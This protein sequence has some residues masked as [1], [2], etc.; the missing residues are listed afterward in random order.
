MVPSRAGS[1]GRLDIG[2]AIHDGWL[3]FSRAPWAFVLFALLLTGLQ[4]L[5]QP[6]QEQV[7]KGARGEPLSSADWLLFLVGLI[8]SL[9]VSCWGSVGMVR[10][11]WQA[12]DGQR[13]SLASLLR[14]DGPGFRRVFTAWMS[15]SS[16]LAVPLLAI[17]LLLLLVAVGLWLIERAGTRLSDATLQMPGLLLALLVLLLLGVAALVFLYF[18]VNQQFLAQIAL[19]EERGPLASVRRGRSLG[20]PHWLL[21]LLLALIKATLLLLG[22]LA[23]AVGLM[24]AWPVS[25]CITTA[26]YRQL[27][28]RESGRGPSP[29]ALSTPAGS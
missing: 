26:A 9:A 20:D 28:S 12:L 27:V 7:L 25:T 3:A 1:S 2:D 4:I 11:A 23:F 19:L 18:G 5:L 8:A 29:P 13:P 17:L 24:V 10:G 22:V 14:W 6:L 21:L 15:L 16:L